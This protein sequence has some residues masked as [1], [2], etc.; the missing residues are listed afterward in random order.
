M[1]KHHLTCSAGTFIYLIIFFKTQSLHEKITVLGIGVYFYL[2][3]HPFLRS[4]I[5]KYKIYNVSFNFNVGIEQESNKMLSVICFL[6]SFCLGIAQ[7]YIQ[8]LSMN[9]YSTFFFYLC[10]ALLIELGSVF[11]PRPKCQFTY[12]IFSAGQGFTN[13]KHIL[14]RVQ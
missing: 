10:Q 2:N 9:C 13:N 6:F 7:N 12:A 14:F 1:E 5:K 11:F 8:L 3:A 4:Q